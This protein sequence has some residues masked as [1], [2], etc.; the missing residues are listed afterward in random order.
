MKFGPK[1][2]QLHFNQVITR[3]QPCPY[4]KLIICY[5]PKF[6]FVLD[7]NLNIK[8]KILIEDIPELIMDIKFLRIQND[9][10]GSE[11]YNTSGLGFQPEI[12]QYTYYMALAGEM[13]FIKL[14][15][16]F[17]PQNFHIMKGHGSKI[18]RLLNHPIYDHLLFSCSADTTIRMWDVIKK[19]TVCV[20]GGLCGHEDIVLSIDISKDGKWLVSGG[21]DNCIKVWALSPIFEAAA[22]QTQDSTNTVK[23]S[24]SLQVNSQIL[25]SGILEIKKHQPIRVHFPVFST[26]VLNKSY[27]NHLELY[28]NVI[29]SKNLSHRVSI[30]V[31]EG[32]FPAFADKPLGFDPESLY[33]R[34]SSS[35][36][37][38]TGAFNEHVISQ[39]EKKDW[40]NLFYTDE[41][42]RSIQNH[43]LNKSYIY[44]NSFNSNT[45]VLNDYK[46]QKL[47][48]KFVI[49]QEKC[50][51][52][53]KDGNCYTIDL[54]SFEKVRQEIKIAEI[55]DFII[56]ENHI[57]AITHHDRI[58][59]Y[60]VLE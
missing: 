13:A 3:I 9:S 57:F 2:K 5:G 60:S 55:F 32:M 10:H 53:E 43:Q 34:N 29:I 1:I 27:I 17:A 59:C 8:G 45:I 56:L 52:F 21:S 47:I 42:S 41:T 14:I 19:E 6:I 58:E 23:S 51:L 16:L 30:F 39:P 28:G 33:S 36:I 7:Y 50:V 44:K 26:Q 35:K 20:F 48:T 54:E 37:T 4:F 24:Q 15:D 40:C 12:V 25:A 46:F 18:I 49:F 38:K 22:R 31:F 11:T